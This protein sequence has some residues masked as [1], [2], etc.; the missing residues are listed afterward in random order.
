MGWKV[1][2]SSSGKILKAG[3]E[4]EDTALDWLETNENILDEDKLYDVEEM[5]EDDEV[6]YADDEEEDSLALDLNDVDPDLDED[7]ADDED[8]ETLGFSEVDEDDEF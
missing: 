7:D 5:D 8:D 4:D 6:D 2:D 1:V 3:F